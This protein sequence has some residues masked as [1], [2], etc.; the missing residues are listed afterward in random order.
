MTEKMIYDDIRPYRDDE[1]PEAMQRIADSASFP[2]LAAYVFPD[3]DVHAVKEMIK[4]I[5]IP[6][7]I[8]R[9][10]NISLLTT[11]TL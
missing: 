10:G 11:K 6:I 1:I 8:D 7:K 2:L 9:F 4:S 3:R 5:C